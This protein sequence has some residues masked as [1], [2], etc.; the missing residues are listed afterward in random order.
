MGANPHLQKGFFHVLY[1]IIVREIK[2]IYV[3]NFYISKALTCKNNYLGRCAFL[4][5]MTSLEGKRTSLDDV[6]SVGIEEFYKCT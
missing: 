2:K 5:W 4:R 1:L 3:S 6:N